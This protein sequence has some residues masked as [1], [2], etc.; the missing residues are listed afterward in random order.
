MVRQRPPSANMSSSLASRFVLTPPYVGE[1]SPSAS[2]FIYYPW[3]STGSLE[4]ATQRPWRAGS[5]QTDKKAVDAGLDAG[6]SPDQ[7]SLSSL[8]IEYLLNMATIY[9]EPPL[10]PLPVAAPSKNPALLTVPLV[11]HRHLRGPSDVPSDTLSRQSLS[12]FFPNRIS[13]DDSSTVTYPSAPH[14]TVSTR[15]G[16]SSYSTLALG[17]AQLSLQ[18]NTL[19]PPWASEHERV[20]SFPVSVTSSLSPPR[21]PWDEQANPNSVMIS[22]A[23]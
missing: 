13:R 3:G 6:L 17:Q 11:H 1:K 21:P 12:E 2:E 16:L 14:L 10:R 7:Q 20:S 23:L 4:D 22:W 18:P 8:D 9:S 19:V 5:Q 15:S